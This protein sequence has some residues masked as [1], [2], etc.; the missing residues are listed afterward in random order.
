MKNPKKN[1]RKCGM[2]YNVYIPWCFKNDKIDQLDEEDI[3]WYYKEY[4]K[5]KNK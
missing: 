3:K 4:L 1:K 5:K 2:Y